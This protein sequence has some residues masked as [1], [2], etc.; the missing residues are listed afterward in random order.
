MIIPDTH[1]LLST[2]LHNAL[3]NYTYGG[4]SA[5]NRRMLYKELVSVIRLVAQ[6]PL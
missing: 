3:V 2:Y 6:E 1:A 4:T 5:A